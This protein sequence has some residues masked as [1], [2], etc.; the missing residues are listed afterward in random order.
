M[1]ISAPP[2]GLMAGE[3]RCVY[4]YG[5]YNDFVSLDDCGLWLSLTRADF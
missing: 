2:Y 4:V 1:W 5:H 3:G